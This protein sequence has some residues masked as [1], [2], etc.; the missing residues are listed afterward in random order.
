MEEKYYEA[1]VF[2]DLK[3]NDEIFEGYKFTDCEFENCVFESCRLLSC[4]F[5][6]CSFIK[7]TVMSLEAEAHSRIQYVEFDRCNLIG[8]HW[9]ELMPDGAFAEPIKGFYGCRLKYNTFSE[10]NLKKFDFTG[11]EISD[12]M[13]A[14][15]RLQESRMKGCKLEGT[16]FF[17]CD[18]RKADLRGT[19]GYQMDIRSC[20]LNGA[21]FSFPE[22][23]NLLNGLE[24]EIEY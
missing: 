15:C 23:V 12:S 1:Q 16:E 21:R 5:S 3:I 11:N 8:V 22:V 13:F 24:I 4:S 9:E 7:C 19:A 6:G 18:L 17:K 14:D 20:K 10:M 2:K